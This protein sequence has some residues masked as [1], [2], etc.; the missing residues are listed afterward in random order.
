MEQITKPKNKPICKNLSTIQ[1]AAIGVD[2]MRTD[3]FHLLEEQL[4]V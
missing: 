3:G 2:V 1:V 4:D